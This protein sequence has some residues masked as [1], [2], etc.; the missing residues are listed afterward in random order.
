MKRAVLA[1]AFLAL[2]TVSATAAEFEIKMLNKGAAGAMV[3]EPAFLKIAP[4]DKVKFVPIDKGHNA[5][6]IPE[7]SPAG[8][9]PFIGKINEEMD[10]TFTQSGVYGVK[11]KPHYAMGMV[12]LIVVGEP[13]NLE[14][15]SAAK[16][17]GK[18]KQIFA[19]L[20][21]KAR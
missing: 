19:D 3:F 15:A 1:G 9:A 14:E 11:C 21:A 5:E 20:T 17:P 4:G 8:A 7:M 16:H 13:T 18:A 6:S 10:I 12:A 2:A